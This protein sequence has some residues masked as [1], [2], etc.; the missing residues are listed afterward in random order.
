M[1]QTTTPFIPDGLGYY[2]NTV[3][4]LHLASKRQYPPHTCHCREEELKDFQPV[5]AEAE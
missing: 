5:L 2:Q 4:V 3:T 1:S